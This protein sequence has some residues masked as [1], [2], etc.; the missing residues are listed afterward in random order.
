M[1]CISSWAAAVVVISGA[2]I[3]GGKDEP[4]PGGKATSTAPAPRRATRRSQSSSRTLAT[5][6]TA[7]AK[8]PDA[9]STALGERRCHRLRTALRATDSPEVQRR[10]A[11]MVRKMDTERLIA[12]K[13]VTIAKKEKT[14]KAAV[15]EIAK[16]TGYKIEF[17]GGANDE[18]TRLRIRQ[19][20]VLGGDRRVAN[21]AGCV[22]Y[23]RTTTTTT[24]RVYNQDSMNPHVAYAGP[25]RF[26]A[27]N[28]NSSN[29]VQLSGVPRRGGSRTA[30]TNM[31]LSFQIQSEPKNPMLGVTQPEIISAVDENGG[32]LMPPK[33][34]NDR[35]VLRQPGSFRGHNTYGNLNLT[36][37]DKTATTIKSL[38]AKIGIML[39]SGTEPRDRGRRPA[40]GEE[41]D[42]R[43]ADD[44]DRL[45]LA[46]RGREQQGA[47]RA[48]PDGAKTRRQRPQPAR[49]QLEQ[50]RL[51]EDRTHSTRAETSTAPQARTTQTT[52]ATAVQMTI[53]FGNQD[54]RGNHV[55][56]ARPAGEDWWSTS[57]CR[58]PTR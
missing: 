52:T 23:T 43:R 14:V 22:V 37:G 5:T 42:V 12:P 38:K 27:T 36:R 32:S 39:L 7:P 46:R 30:T 21:A 57:G 6:I 24:I 41:E 13:R 48:G 54:R 19:H 55:G 8:R 40:E 15:D 10:L 53:P 45:R 11:V 56:Q 20:A 18:Q 26:L 16:Q 9:S 51:A 47:V 49:L 31:N 29:S 50:H 34:R 1:R 44:R 3:A 4:L 25:F 35:V 58:S 17:S 28:I 2:V 33:T